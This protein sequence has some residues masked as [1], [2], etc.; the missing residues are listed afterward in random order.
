MMASHI[1]RKSSIEAEPRWPANLSL[2]FADRVPACLVP[3]GHLRSARIAPLTCEIMP[4]VF[5]C[6][7]N[8]QGLARKPLPRKVPTVTNLRESFERWRDGAFD[9]AEAEKI[10]TLSTNALRDLQRMGAL[11]ASGGGGRSNRRSWGREALCQAAMAAEF[12]KAGLSL[13]M[14]AR[15]SFYY[16]NIGGDYC[17]D[18]FLRFPSW[19]NLISPSFRE[20]TRSDGKNA[21]LEWLSANFARPLHDEE[22]DNFVH[23]IDAVY[24]I[25]D[26]SAQH[27]RRI[28]DEETVLEIMESLDPWFYPPMGRITDDGK[29]FLVWDPPKRQHFLSKEKLS[30]WKSAEAQGVDIREFLKTLPRV[31]FMTDQY[32]DKI[33]LKFL[34]FQVDPYRDDEAAKWAFHNYTVK[35]SVNVTL[36]MRKAMRRAMNLPSE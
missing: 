36:A 23:I 16:W 11:R 3:G 5:S 35:T 29:R 10:T 6:G 28:E 25:A 8:P 27:L 13:A 15:L 17:F 1:P 14:G 7:A 9:D 21:V 2:W 12:R 30:A 34:D 24:V 19:E 31:D 32:G 20:E 4:Q 33:D 26:C 18:P 22:F